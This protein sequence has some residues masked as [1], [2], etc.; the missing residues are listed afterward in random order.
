MGIHTH[1][2]KEIHL[3]RSRSQ[4]G[5]RTSHPLIGVVGLP[6]LPIIRGSSITLYFLINHL[7]KVLIYVTFPFIILDRIVIS[8]GGM[9]I[10]GVTLGFLTFLI[11]FSQ[12]RLIKQDSIYH[13]FPPMLLLSS[14][15]DIKS[16]W[17][18][19]FGTTPNHTNTPPVPEL[20]LG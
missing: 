8:L 6:S 11:D 9:R 4:G 10:S 15:V 17:A 3:S 14:W 7:G 2:P 16:I 13:I 5:E 18:R 20:T 12:T 1:I 19:P